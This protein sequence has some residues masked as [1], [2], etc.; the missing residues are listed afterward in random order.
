MPK[1][2]S[3]WARRYARTVRKNAERWAAQRRRENERAAMTPAGAIFQF[4]RVLGQTPEELARERER[5]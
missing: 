1:K 3:G 5:K 4:G 2:S